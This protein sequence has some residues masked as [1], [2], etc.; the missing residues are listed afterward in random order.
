MASPTTRE[1]WREYCTYEPTPDSQRPSLSADEIKA[2]GGKAV[3]APGDVTDLDAVKGMLRKAEEAFGRVDVLVNNAGNAGAVPDPE[4]R[5]PFWE[6]GPGAWNSFIGV[7]FYGVI[8]C[9]S[10]CIPPMIERR[11]GRIITIISDAGRTGEA[12]LEIYSGAKAGAAGFTRAVYGVKGWAYYA[13]HPLFWAKIGVFERR[14]I[15]GVRGSPAADLDVLALI[16]AAR[17]IGGGQVGNARQ[18]VVERREQI[19][20]LG[21]QRG[22]RVLQ[23]SHF[24]LEPLGLILVAPAHRRADQLRGFVATPLCFLHPGGDAAPLAVQRQDCSGLRFQPAPGQARVKQ[25]GI[26]TDKANVMH[27]AQA[28]ARSRPRFQPMQREIPR[29]WW[30]RQGLN[31]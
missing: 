7:N 12:G 22:E 9:A 14:E 11:S 4:A 29:E 17:R 31:L 23:R 28:Y 24:R 25:F 6:T 27:S 30:A 19:A 10:V 1:E 18:H 3:A 2:L 5:K 16:L 15:E 20:V 26:L 8:N 13:H 21:L